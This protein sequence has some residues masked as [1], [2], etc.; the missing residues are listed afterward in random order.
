MLVKDPVR[1]MSCG[2]LPADLYVALPMSPVRLR[3]VDTNTSYPKP[4]HP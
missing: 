4:L 1:E 3:M 2:Q